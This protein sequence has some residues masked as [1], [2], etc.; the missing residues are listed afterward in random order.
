[1]QRLVRVEARALRSFLGIPLAAGGRSLRGR[2]GERID[3]EALVRLARRT[4]A[5][6][7]EQARVLERREVCLRYFEVRALLQVE[8]GALQRGR[9][10]GRRRLAAA[11]GLRGLVGL[12]HHA[13]GAVALLLDSLLVALVARALLDQF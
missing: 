9:D 10:R 7:T 2:L 11:L 12:V 5:G 1:L 6:R 13:L 8:A 3:A 4:R